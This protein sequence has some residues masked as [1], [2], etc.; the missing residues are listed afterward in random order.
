MSPLVTPVPS[1]ARAALHSITALLILEQ[2]R[3]RAWEAKQRPKKLKKKKKKEKSLKIACPVQ[4]QER[5]ANSLCSAGPS[6]GFLQGSWR[7]N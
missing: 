5:K 3:E 1:K 4:S 7:I 6:P 2:K